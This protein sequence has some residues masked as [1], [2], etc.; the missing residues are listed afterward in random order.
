MNRHQFRTLRNAFYRDKNNSYYTGLKKLELPFLRRKITEI[1]IGGKKIN[2][3]KDVC[4]LYRLT[5]SDNTYDFFSVEF[6]GT[7]T[8]YIITKNDLIIYWVTSS[9]FAPAIDAFHLLTEVYHGYRDKD[10]I[11]QWKSVEDFSCA[12]MTM[13]EERRK[14]WN[15]PWYKNLHSE[16]QE[17]MFAKH[18]L[19]FID[20]RFIT[21]EQADELASKLYY[22]T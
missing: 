17:E 1:K 22:H 11:Y 9:I 19:Y 18:K 8:L 7:E 4:F 14:N 20:K 6:K 10:A 15:Q 12:D 13:I 21:Q 3:E 2:F 16:Y 5:K